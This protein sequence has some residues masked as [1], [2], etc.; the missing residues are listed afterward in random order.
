MKKLVLLVLAVFATLFSSNLLAQGYSAHHNGGG[1]NGGYGGHCQ[2][3]CWFKCEQNYNE[4]DDVYVRVD[5][6]RYQDIEYME[7]YVNGKFVRKET[8]YPF[9]WCRK[10]GSDDRYLRKLKVGYYK[11]CVKIR[12]KCG[13]YHEKC[14][15][16]CVK[17][18]HNDGGHDNNDHNGGGHNGPCY[19]GCGHDGGHHGGYECN[20]DFWFKY[21]QHNQT[22]GEGENIYVR[23]DTKK[24]KDIKYM[25]LYVNGKFVRKETSYPYEW[26]VG[27]GSSDYYLRKV[28]CGT[29]KICVRVLD[30]CGDWHEECRVVYVKKYPL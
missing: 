28:K 18:G 2:W 21:P 13:D 27:H 30:N 25:D 6:K 3:D 17:G 7:L 15:T 23:V 8:S 1:N 10:G 24:Y 14:Y 11:I 4:W 20:W 9:E 12:D 26:C 29:Y 5:P 22:Y 19:P 16:V